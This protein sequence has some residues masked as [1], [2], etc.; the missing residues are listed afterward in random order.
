MADLAF[1][2]YVKTLFISAKT[3]Q[4][5]HRVLG[6]VDEAYEQYTRRIS[7]GLLNDM[8]G[9]A[10]M[11]NEPPTDG[12]RRLK[13]YYATQVSIKPPTFVIFVNQPD[14]MHFSYQR[15]LENYLRK[16]FGFDGTPVRFILR[17][18]KE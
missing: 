2:P 1:M 9:E 12:G 6:L 3:G 7:T 14:L 17:Q 10:I 13:I 8:L 15:Y 4:R 5:I 18:R 16:T 11:L